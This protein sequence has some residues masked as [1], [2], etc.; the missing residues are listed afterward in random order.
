MPSC[1]RN[2]AEVVEGNKR[3]RDRTGLDLTGGMD[4][5]S[6]FIALLRVVGTL[7]RVFCPMG[8]RC[9]VVSDDA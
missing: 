2:G 3:G 9:V 6:D 5:P 7:C 8:G 4:G 1:C